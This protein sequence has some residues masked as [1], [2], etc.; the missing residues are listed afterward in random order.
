MSDPQRPHGLQPSRLLRPW[1]LPGK[2]TGVGCHCLLHPTDTERYKA[3]AAFSEG[4]SPLALTS[5]KREPA[6]QFSPLFPP[7][8]V[9]RNSHLY[10]FFEDIVYKTRQPISLMPPIHSSPHPAL[11]SFIPTLSPE[12]ASP[13]NTLPSTLFPQLC[14][15]ENQAQIGRQASE[16]CLAQRSCIH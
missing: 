9:M 8:T 15:L 13:N 4:W 1:D 11:F 5:R 12:I 10:G 14:F 2:T 16:T 7:R 3:A 6:A